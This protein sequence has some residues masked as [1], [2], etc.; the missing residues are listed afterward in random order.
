MYWRPRTPANA[1]P[2]A[3]NVRGAYFEPL[4]GRSSE[5]GGRAGRRGDPLPPSLPPR[6]SWE[7]SP[8]ERSPAGPRCVR[9]LRGALAAWGVSPFEL[10]LRCFEPPDPRSPARHRFRGRSGAASSRPP[11]PT[12]SIRGRCRGR[13]DASTPCALR[14]PVR[15]HGRGR[16]LE[17][18]GG[19]R[20]RSD[21]RR[22]AD[23]HDPRGCALALGRVPGRSAALSGGRGACLSG[24]R[25][26]STL[27]VLL[28]SFTARGARRRSP[29][30][31]ARSGRAPGG[32]LGPRGRARWNRRSGWPTGTRGARCSAAAGDSPADAKS[33]RP[34]AP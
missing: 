28:R 34:V 12:E 22:W 27:R 4:E 10:S 7:P 16:C 25:S 31:G 5:R 3:T 20:G 15:C 30:A 21:W 26:R 19:R 6:C 11:R 1:D 8:F 2:P 24:V 9:G 32:A 33:S 18:A 13:N 17:P 14:G 29:A 23:R